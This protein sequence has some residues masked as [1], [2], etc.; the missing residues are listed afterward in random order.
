[1]GAIKLDKVRAL[2]FKKWGLNADDELQRKKHLNKKRKNVRNQQAAA[3]H[4]IA[5]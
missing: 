4:H 3:V 1:V 5:A 2:L